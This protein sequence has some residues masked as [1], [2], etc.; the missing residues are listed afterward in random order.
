M[1]KQS[2]QAIIIITGTPGTGNTKLAKGFGGVI[3]IPVSFIVDR[4]GNLVKRLDGYISQKVFDR[5]LSKLLDEPE[6]N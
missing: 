1:K 5:E 2:K 4:E 6:K 3:G